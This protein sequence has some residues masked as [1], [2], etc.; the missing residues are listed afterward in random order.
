MMI[1]NF[2]PRHIVTFSALIPLS[3]F[4]EASVMNKYGLKPDAETLDIANTAARQKSIYWGDP[5]EKICEALD[6]IPLSSL[7]GLERMIMG[8]VSNH[9]VNNVACPVTV[10]EARVQAYWGYCEQERGTYGKRFLH[11]LEQV[12]RR[13]GTRGKTEKIQSHSRR[14]MKKTAKVLI[15]MPKNMRSSQ[16]VVLSLLQNKEDVNRD[17]TKYDHYGSAT[18]IMRLK[19]TIQ[20]L[21]GRMSSVTEKS[22]KGSL[23]SLS[24]LMISGELKMYS[25]LKQFTFLDLELATRNFRPESLLGESGF[26]CVFKGWM[27]ENGTAPVKPGTGLTVAVKTL[28]LDGLQGHKEWLV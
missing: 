13:A 26:G 6:H 27:E 19:A 3:E 15:V 8:S 20:S 9:V 22:A 10:F 4:S 17:W 5:R 16:K 18:M 14:V 1:T 25:H 21:E 2:A 23:S 24:T 11:R 12:E 28:N 7:G